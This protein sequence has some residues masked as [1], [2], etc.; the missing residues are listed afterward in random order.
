M[1]KTFVRIVAFFVITLASFAQ[2]TKEGA[3]E[4][5]QKGPC[6]DAAATQLDLNKCFAEESHKADGHLNTIYANL[7]EQMQ[8]A[9]AQKL[10]AAERAW[11]Q[12]RDL[13]C[14]AARFEYEGG[15]MSPMVFAQCMATTTEHRIEDLKAA[16]D[17]RKLE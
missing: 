3:E 6:D 5:R 15:S 12:Y 16:Y 10:K 9:A 17:E 11:I 2:N 13:H 4:T 1:S 14:E 8:G 7:L